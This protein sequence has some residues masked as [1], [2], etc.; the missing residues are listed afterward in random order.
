[1]EPIEVSS[2]VKILGIEVPNR[3]FDF[4]QNKES[5]ELR[6]KWSWAG[7]HTLIGNYLRSEARKS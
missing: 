2:Q 5:K 4:M 7:K 3:V 6:I 1:M